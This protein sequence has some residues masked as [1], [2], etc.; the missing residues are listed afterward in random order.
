[1][2]RSA[3]LSLL[4]VAVAAPA[5]AETAATVGDRTITIAEVEKQVRPQ[6]V[7]I[8]QQRFDALSAGLDQI[9]DEELL[10]REAKARGVTPAELEKTEIEAKI[11]APTPEE[12]KAL[13]DQ[14]AAEIG[15]TFEQVQGQLTDYIR[16]QRGTAA[17]G[18]FLASL[19]A[20]YPVKVALLPPRIE[21]GTGG[22]A[23]RGPQNAPVTII[24]FSD[25]ECPFCKKGEETVEKVVET[26]GDKVRLVHRDFPLSFHKDA[27][28]AAQ[29]ARCSE[30]QG[31]FWEYHKKL[32]ASTDLSEAGLNTIAEQVGLDLAKFKECVSSGKY[33]DAVDRDMADGAAVGVTGTPAFFI[34]GRVLSGAQPFEKFKEIIDAELAAK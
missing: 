2:I 21:V 19:R 3:A 25:Y 1:M 9:I 7:E 12:V 13:Y 29:A 34:N 23:A 27:H 16:Q 24:S 17:R 31:K 18:A 10:S 32:F 20:K 6:L 8:E 15:G 22:R 4:L 5:W 33:K 26:Y 11:A 14:H 30:D 28:R